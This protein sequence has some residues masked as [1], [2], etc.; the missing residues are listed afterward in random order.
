LVVALKGD[1]MQLQMT[2]S[3]DYSVVMLLFI[4]TSPNDVAENSLG[5]N[6]SSSVGADISSSITDVQRK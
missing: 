4:A 1:A 2:A 5:A 3:I 6:P